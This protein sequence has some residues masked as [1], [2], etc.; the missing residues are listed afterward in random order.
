M[1]FTRLFPP[2]SLP[3]GGFRLR[4]DQHNVWQTTCPGGCIRG[5]RYFNEW[6][7]SAMAR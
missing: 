5:P 6:R 4:D 2:L 1:A 3:Q 7:A